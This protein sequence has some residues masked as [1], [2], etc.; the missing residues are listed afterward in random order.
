MPDSRLCQRLNPTIGRLVLAVT[1]AAASA[2]GAARIDGQL[3][4]TVIDSATQQPIAVRLELRD[5]RGRLARMAPQGAVVTGD[6]VYF[7][8]E[9]LLELRRGKYSLLLEAGPEYQTFFTQPGSLEIVRGAAD[10]KE[11][12]MVRRVDMHQEDWF[13]G[14]LDVHLPADALSTVMAARGVDVAAVVGVSNDFG[15]CERPKPAADASG[16]AAALDRRGGGGLLIVGGDEP[17][18]VC[19][20][21]ADASRIA[22]L[23]AAREAGAVTVARQAAAWALPL[24]VAT[25]QLDAVQ[26]L[27]APA[28]QRRGSKTG[29]LTRPHDR[30]FFP[31]KQGPARFAEL[32]YHKL[33]ECGLR[34]APAAGSAAGQTELPLGAN[35]VYVHCA[36]EFTPETWLAGLRAGRV[37]VSNGPLLRPLVEGQPPGSVFHLAPGQTRSFQIGLNLAF[38]SQTHIEYLEIIKN[39]KVLHTVRLDELAQAAGRL[40]EVPFEASGWFLVRAVTNAVDEYQYATS[41]AFFVE[42][43]YQPRVSRSAVEFFVAW[44]DELATEF[45]GQQAMQDDLAAARPFWQRLLEQANAE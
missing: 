29:A 4:L 28:E 16:L 38:Y 11:I 25:G 41:G 1:M 15:R 22:P 17:V 45:A 9:A 31:G 13:A 26:I 6:G 20:W 42:Q 12:A 21:S 14:D 37:V 39:G 19:Q 40:P 35:R 33:L 27:H 24:W 18:D 7:A 36:D 34:I 23:Q 43:A 2:A 10:A 32:I 3:Q 8:G 44:L 30:T 5:A